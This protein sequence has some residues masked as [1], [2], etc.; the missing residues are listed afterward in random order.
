MRLSAGAVESRPGVYGRGTA[1]FGA[2][3]DVAKL[4]YAADFDN[5]SARG[6]TCGAEPLK[7]GE[8]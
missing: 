1:P 7:F 2:R 8:S 5:W 6:E 3:A 4:V